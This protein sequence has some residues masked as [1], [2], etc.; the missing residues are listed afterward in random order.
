MSP[1]AQGPGCSVVVLGV[2]VGA[3]FRPMAAN[4]ASLLPAVIAEGARGGTEAS[5]LP[6]RRRVAALVRYS[7]PE[8][9]VTAR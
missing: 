5:R 7:S 8:R 9:R 6:E 2:R 3:R 1:G 4:R